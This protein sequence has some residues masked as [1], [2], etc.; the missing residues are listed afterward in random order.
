MDRKWVAADIIRGD[1]GV[2]ASCLLSQ[3]GRS[4]LPKN[5]RPL[6]PH[7]K[8][9]GRGRG[10]SG[11][12]GPWWN[13]AGFG[14][15]DRVLA[16]WGQ[17]GCDIQ[18][19]VKQLTIVRAWVEAGPAEPGP[20]HPPWPGRAPLECDGEDTACPELARETTLVSHR[21]KKKPCVVYT[22]SPLHYGKGGW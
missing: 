13:V 8:E 18:A 12:S 7:P 16:G 19:R 22:A 20:S 6:G 9:E 5:C 14:V 15:G 10:A 3:S 1:R 17:V 11:L 4:R 21:K 2:S